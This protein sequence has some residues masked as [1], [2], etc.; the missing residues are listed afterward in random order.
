[1]EPRE[2]IARL[3]E[4]YA[5]IDTWLVDATLSLRR[6]KLHLSEQGLA[7]Y[8]AP[9]LRILANQTEIAS[10]R[11]VGVRVVGAHARVDLH[12]SYG[13]RIIVY[14]SR[15]GP[16]LATTAKTGAKAVERHAR[17]LFRG[18]EAEGWYTVDRRRL[19]VQPLS[20][21]QF[22]NLLREVSDRAA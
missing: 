20:A 17:P 2:F 18:V 7:P 8:D 5:L 22:R 1:M 14:L 6:G 4:L 16:A 13:T 21:D 10:L 19:V 12:G 11:P 15:G 9:T 3:N